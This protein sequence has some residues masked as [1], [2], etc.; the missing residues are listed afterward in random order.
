MPASVSI[1]SASA[2]GR[3]SPA[4]TPPSASA[5][6]STATKPGPDPDSPVTASSSDSSASC[7]LPTARSSS[8]TRAKRSAG[9][10]A[11]RQATETPRPTRQG[12]LGMTRTT[13]R[14]PVMSAIAASDRPATIDTTTASAGTARPQQAATACCGLTARMTVSAPVTASAAEAAKRISGRR[15]ASRSR[16]GG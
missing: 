2:S 5:S 11:V 10:S 14:V 12:V 16:A 6:T 1:A 3:G 15:A 4:R 13:R 9:T 7:T 8:M